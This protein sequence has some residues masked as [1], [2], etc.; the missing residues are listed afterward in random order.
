M[1]TTFTEFF[2]DIND[3]LREAVRQLGGHK[4]VGPAM[5]PELP[6][7]SAANWLRDCLNHE[8]REK[9][10]PEQVVLILRMA[11]DTGFHGAMSFVAFSAGY[12]PPAPISVDEQDAQLQHQFIEAVGKLENIQKQLQRGQQLRRAA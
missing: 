7:E 11:R 4:K 6:L 12:E 10:S 1:Q 9:L 2:E 5:R 8:R 3:A